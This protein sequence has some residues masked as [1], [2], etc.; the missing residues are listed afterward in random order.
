MA[1]EIP[2]SPRSTQITCS[3][4]GCRQLTLGTAGLYIAR[5]WNGDRRSVD[6][7]ILALFTTKLTVKS[8]RRNGLF[9]RRA[10]SGREVVLMVRSQIRKGLMLPQKWCASSPTQVFAAQ[11]L[12]HSDG[13]KNRSPRLRC[14]LQPNGSTHQVLVHRPEAGTETGNVFMIACI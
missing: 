14:L 9:T 7:H 3:T 5:K 2:P 8:L 1:T 13:F 11:S 12:C 4:S 10:M 6:E